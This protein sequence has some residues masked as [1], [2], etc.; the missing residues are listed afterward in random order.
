MLLYYIICPVRGDGAKMVTPLI[1][2]LSV[3]QTRIS[4]STDYFFDLVPTNSVRKVDPFDFGTQKVEG[5]VIHHC[6]DP[7]G[8]KNAKEGDSEPCK[9]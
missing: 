5:V 1:S 6:L 7:E 4:V 3:Q 8:T 2:C 9:V